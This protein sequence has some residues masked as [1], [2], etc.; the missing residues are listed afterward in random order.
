MNF[1]VKI[2]NEEDALKIEKLSDD[3]LENLSKNKVEDYFGGVDK[4]EV[5]EAMKFPSITL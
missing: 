4:D 5:L 3:I 2:A 1:T